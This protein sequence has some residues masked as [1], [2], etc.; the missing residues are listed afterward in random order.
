MGRAALLGCVA[1]GLAAA[2]AQAQPRVKAAG[3]VTAIAFSA[4][5]Q[6]LAVGHA[7]GVTLWSM[8]KRGEPVDLPPL[9]KPTQFVGFA[10]EQLAAADADVLVA[11]DLAAAR[12]T[13]RLDL[14]QRRAAAAGGLRLLADPHGPHLAVVALAASGEGTVEVFD[15]AAGRVVT[16]ISRVRADHQAAWSADGGWLLLDGAAWAWDDLRSWKPK[17]PGLATVGAGGKLLAYVD[18]AACAD[19]IT[20]VEPA[21]RKVL[22]TIDPGD[23]GCPAD[24]WLVDGGRALVWIG[25][26]PGKRSDLW[27]WEAERDRVHSIHRDV[28]HHPAAALSADERFIALP[29]GAGVKFVST[30]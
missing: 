12:E 26:P 30:R 14:G 6:W 13:F 28:A 18:P 22:R 2:P 27:R 29:D 17:N 25:G 20:L 3:E 5:G 7:A 8:K 1:V 23:G 21:A 11:W 15:L 10:G 16:A 4:D 24:M 19:G 9:G